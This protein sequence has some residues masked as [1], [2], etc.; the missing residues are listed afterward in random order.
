MARVMTHMV[1]HVVVTIETSM[2]MH[3]VCLNCLQKDFFFTYH[4]LFLKKNPIFT[5]CKTCAPPTPHT[6][7]HTR[8]AW[9]LAG[10][11]LYVGK[12]SK[13]G[14]YKATRNSLST[15]KIDGS[16]QNRS[17]GISISSFVASSKTGRIEAR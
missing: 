4:V 8:C 10:F 16:T 7:T 9:L 5:S 13:Q 12:N 14:R 6:H 2:Q 11:W 1:A 3:Q 17:L 15:S